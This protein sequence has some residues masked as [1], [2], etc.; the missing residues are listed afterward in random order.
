MTAAK[1]KRLYIHIGTHK[2]GSSSL[3]HWLGSNR[4]RLEQTGYAY[5]TGA[6][7]PDNHVELFAVPMRPGREAFAREKY[8]IVGSETELES[9]R[10]R[11][12]AFA[13]R[14][15]EDNLILSCE[16]LSLLRFDDEID[17]FRSIIEPTDREVVVVLV[18]RNKGD[19]LDSFRRQI[20]KHRDR[21][22]SDDPSS[23]RYVEPDSWLADYDA[24][25]DIWSRSFPS[26]PV[27]VVD[28][29]KSIALEGDVLPSVIRALDLPEAVIPEP[30]TIR[31][32][33]DGW[34]EMVRRRLRQV[35]IRL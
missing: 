23:V 1:G 4:D 18:L 30:G 31:I 16:G 33:A 35:G 17:R 22:L 15:P 9:L 29:D 11:F 32:N 21:E 6:F 8:G 5:F 27:R 2:T 26:A 13:A 14:H 28:Y 10:N 3:Q 7:E 25:E 20:I 34:K 19:F 24:I 12:Q